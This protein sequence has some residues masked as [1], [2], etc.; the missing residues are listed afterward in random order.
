MSDRSAEAVIEDGVI[1]IR[2]PIDNLAD[3]L[4][5]A[6]LMMTISPAYKVTDAAVF[7]KEVVREL[8]SE[9]EEGT[10]AVHKM[11]D[12]AFNEA[13]EQGAEGVE[14]CTEEE[15]EKLGLA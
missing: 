13:I 15:A 5:G 12:A 11:F 4:K 3:A 6:C 14:E 10:T 2:L 7:A 8:N 9:D 1:V